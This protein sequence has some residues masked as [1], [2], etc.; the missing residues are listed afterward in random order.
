MAER[1]KPSFNPT[2]FFKPLYDK[3]DYDHRISNI[4][5]INLKIKEILR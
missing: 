5:R 1:S 2:E 4:E 3:G